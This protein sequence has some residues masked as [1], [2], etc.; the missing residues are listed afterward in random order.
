[1]T[2]WLGSDP[3]IAIS[4]AEGFPADVHVAVASLV[5][6][7]L[8]AE[9]G[10]G[11]RRDGAVVVLVLDNMPDAAVAKA[12]RAGVVGLVP[13]A[14]M[15]R[16]RLVDEVVMAADARERGERTTG[17]MLADALCLARS[18]APDRPLPLL[19]DRDG[20]LLRLLSLGWNSEEI[21]R[22]TSLSPRTVVARVDRVLRKCGARNRCEAI[23]RA[24]QVG[25][26]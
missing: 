13:R 12:V 22:R 6:Q 11:A 18:A 5:D 21:A 15:S 2:S 25:L 3:R 24:A 16:D 26:L 20:E 1:M 19:D 17:E 4:D 14:A 8:L 23:A 9:L 7:A 10:A